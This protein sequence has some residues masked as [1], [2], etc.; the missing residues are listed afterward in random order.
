M[1]SDGLAIAVLCVYAGCAVLAIVWQAWCCHS[2]PMIWWLYVAERLTCGLLWKV[3]LR[4]ADGR[5]ARCPFPVDSAALI[6]GNHR[7]PVDPIVLWQNHHLASARRIIRP[8]GFLMAREYYEK[9]ALNWFFKAMQAI[10]VTR[11]VQDTGAVRQAIHRLKAGELVGIF[12]EGGINDGPPG[13]RAANPGVAFLALNTDAPVYPV[14][15][16]AAP[17][18]DSMVR[19]FF[20]PSRVRLIYGEPIFLTDY[21]EQK[22]SQELLREVTDVIM[23]SVARLG[24]VPYAGTALADQPSQLPHRGSSRSDRQM[25]AATN[26]S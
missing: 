6:V 18:A 22:K 23:N 10:P 25:A 12:P 24:Q 9:P 14:Y 2:G 7:S 21:R 16:E 13:I 19:A 11:D 5:T 4:A 17:T 8:I 1:S 3:R 20:T 26:A 15:I